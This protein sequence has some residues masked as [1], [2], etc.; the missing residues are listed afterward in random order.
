MSKMTAFQEKLIEQLETLPER[1][2]DAMGKM[3]REIAIEESAASD[4]WHDEFEE[5]E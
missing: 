5:D 2:A 4:A 3:V 1:M